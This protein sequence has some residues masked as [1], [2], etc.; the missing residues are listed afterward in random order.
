MY[1]VR[2]TK[3]A[4][5]AIAVQ[6]VRYQNRKTTILKREGTPYNTNLVD[7][8]NKTII[9]HYHNLW[10]VEQAFR[11]AK[12]DLAIRP[13][14]HFKKQTIEAH[15]L[16]CFI[17]LAVCKYMEIKTQKSIKS[18]T[19][20]LKSVTDAHIKNLITNEEIVL[21]FEISEEIQQLLK[22]LSY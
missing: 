7:T 22:T 3:T 12:N 20:L 21:R 16:I 11:I 4:S 18:I 13:I 6:I 19:K 1:H 2:K 5:G 9:N 15:V 14:Y 8:D 10:H 17:A